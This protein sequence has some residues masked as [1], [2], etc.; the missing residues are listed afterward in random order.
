[1]IKKVIFDVDNTLLMH[2][3]MYLQTYQDVLKRY[4]Y[5]ASEEGAR[6]VYRTIGDFEKITTYFRM[7]ELYQYFYQKDPKYSKEFVVDI[8]KSTS[9]WVKPIDED[10]REA[11]D[12]LAQKYD[13]FVLTNWFTK[14]QKE[15][16]ERVG[17]A[18]YF[19]EIIGGDINPVKPSVEAFRCMVKDVEPMECIMI[20]DLPEIDMKGAHEL[21]M[22]TLLYDYKNQYG[23]EPYDRIL[24]WKEIREKL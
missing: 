22:K 24:S 14:E 15:R 18:S 23:E 6:E 9:K 16:L 11:L 7:D 3:P 17:I 13:L 1:M 20:G 12:Y 4:G 19:K 5:E 2:D 8:I 21:G 10:L